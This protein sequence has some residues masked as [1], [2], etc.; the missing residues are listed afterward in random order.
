LNPATLGC[1]DF[2]ASGSQS[3][4]ELT[5]LPIGFEKVGSPGRQ[6][7]IR[8]QYADIYLQI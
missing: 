1:H 7:R 5:N 8:P 3:S 6:A 2:G 4:G